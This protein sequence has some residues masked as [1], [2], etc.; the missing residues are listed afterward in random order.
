[1]MTSRNPCP[2]A[3]TL[4]ELLVVVAIISMLMSITLPA[5]ERARKLGYRTDCL[6]TMRQ[7]TLAWYFY[8]TENEMRLCSPGTLWNDFPGSHYWVADGPILPPPQINPIANTPQA[9]KDGVLWPYTNNLDLYKCKDDPT[10]LLRSYSIAHTMGGQGTYEGE[11]RPFRRYDEIYRPSE[12]MVFVDASSLIWLHMGFTPIQKD[13]E[14]WLLFDVGS[15][16]YTARHGGG[17]N[18]SF[19]D[20]HC[21]FFKWNYRTMPLMKMFHNNSSESMRRISKD[22]PDLDRF[23]RCFKGRRF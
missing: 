23:L 5:L 3:F 7:L 9:I 22:N 2:R 16:G 1:M 10:Y 12:Q 14:T 17:C 4:V 11:I 21:E 15:N 19:A 8:A 6:S 13:E 18:I 20:M